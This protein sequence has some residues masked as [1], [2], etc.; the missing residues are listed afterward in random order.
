MNITK[1][2]QLLV[3]LVVLA[4]AATCFVPMSKAEAAGNDP[5]DVNA[6]AAI[7]IE[8][9]SGKILYSKNADKRLPIA[10]MTKMM[11]EYLLLEAI[12]EGKVKWDQTYTP[13]DYVYEISQDNSLSNVPLRKDGKYTVKELY[14]A[15][16]IYS[17][18]GAAIAVAEILAGTETKFVAE[19]NAKA[20]ELGM[21]NYDF[22]NATGLVNE[23]LHGKQPQGEGVKEESEVSA[24]DMALLA[25]RLITDYPEVLETTSIAKTKFRAGTDDEMD[26]PNWNFMLKGLVSEYPGVDGLKTG[27]TDSAGSCF[28]STAQR[29]GMRVITVVLDAKGNLHTGRFDETK[30]MLDYAFNSNFSMKDL[31]PEGSQ[32]KG[33]KTI[34]VEKGKDK[35][36]DI[37]TDKALSIP[38][39]SGD[40][41]NY[42]A[43]VTL[44]KKEITAPVKK[45][46]K[47]GTLTVTY[48]GSD[49]DYGFLKSKEFS[50]NLVT[51]ND[52]DKAN[53]FVQ[54]MRGIGGFFS[55]IWNSAVDTVTGWF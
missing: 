7:M 18:N 55:G 17:A 40:E 47:V 4:L 38:V 6:S 16:A 11:T 20:K 54:M 8:A 15:M 30:K 29:N 19:M 39:K 48:K 33:H 1:W 52:V 23:D 34:D 36:V 45:G 35:Q 22:K 43:E 2:K 24:K 49:K 26:M 32:V 37:V 21:T 25:D 9:S 12:K 53:W 28:T 51:K 5:I 50:V 41:K 3:S 27:S 46:T 44:D 31:Y 14:Q 42:K 13:D 10:S